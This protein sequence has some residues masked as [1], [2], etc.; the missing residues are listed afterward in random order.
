MSAAVNESEHEDE[1]PDELLG[2]ESDEFTKDDMF[3]LLQNRRRRSVLRY[4]QD[5]DGPVRM[6]DI[7]EQVAAWEHDT[8]VQRLTSKERQRVYIAL[9]QSHLPALD[10]EGVIDYNQDRGIVERRPL[11]EELMPYLD[12]P[13]GT[14]EETAETDTDRDWTSYYLAATGVAAMLFLGTQLEL[15]GLSSELLAVGMLALFGSL[16]G[17]NAFSAR[18]PTAGSD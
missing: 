8:T 16:S 12:D 5:T 2:D 7:A 3:H 13:T 18:K 14:E 15:V 10:D 1:V 17:A 4:L 9:Y 11:A 6:R